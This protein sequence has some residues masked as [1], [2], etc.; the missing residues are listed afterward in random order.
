MFIH[1]SL[2]LVYQRSGEMNGIPLFRY[3]APKTMFANGSDYPPNEGFCPCRQSGLLN[4][5]SCRYSE[6]ACTHFDLHF[7]LDVH[8]LWNKRLEHWCPTGCIP[9]ELPLFCFPDSPVFISHPHFF[10]A[11]PV[12][13]DYVL[14]LH[15]NEDE[16]GL[17]IDIHPVSAHTLAYT[18]KLT[19]RRY[20]NHSLF[21]GDVTSKDARQRNS[22]VHM[23]TCT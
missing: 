5:S 11:D 1:R 9:H 17:F 13:L 14:G 15:P 12:L 8:T 10:N 7:L 16:H 2:E 19:V 3:V 23:H 20:F 4:V 6:S 18:I 22:D 21:W